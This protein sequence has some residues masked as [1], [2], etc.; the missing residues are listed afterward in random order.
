M[1]L[2]ASSFD[3]F[4]QSLTS[5]LTL[6]WVSSPSNKSFFQTARSRYMIGV[7]SSCGQLRESSF[8]TSTQRS[9]SR[10]NTFVLRSMSLP[11]DQCSH[12]VSNVNCSVQPP[13]ILYNY[14]CFKTVFFSLASLRQHSCSYGSQSSLFSHSQSGYRYSAG[15]GFIHLSFE[16]KIAFSFNIL[17]SRRSADLFL[18]SKSLTASLLLATLSTPHSATR[19]YY[20]RLRGIIAG[21]KFSVKA[22]LQL[23]LNP[24]KY[25]S[26]YFN[27]NDTYKILSHCPNSRRTFRFLVCNTP[28]S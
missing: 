12:S 6:V 18:C 26:P 20:R 25:A 21:D 19:I 5:Y 27:T 24:S 17:H 11:Q 22:L 1:I 7:I 13:S 14:A 15:S 23:E 2:H 10:S 16:F 28:I 4:K 3:L 9:S 8:S